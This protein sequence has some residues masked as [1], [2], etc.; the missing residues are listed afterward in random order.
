VISNS[1]GAPPA[2]APVRRAQQGGR[3]FARS[4]QFEWL[5][6]AGLA[7]RGA[8]YA[9]IGVLAIKLAFGNGG[10]TTDQQ[11]A[12]AEIAKQPFGKILMGLMAIGLFGYATWR[13][14]RAII[15]HGKE[16]GKDDAKERVGGIASGISYGIFFVTSLTILFGS[17]KSGNSG[18]DKATGG[19]LGWPGGPILVAIAGIVLIGIGLE[20]AY[21][22]IKKKFLEDSKTE[23][24]SEKVK[25][26]FTGLGVFG[27]LARG[28]VFGLIGYF[29]VKAA[30]DFKAKEAV[31][32]DG[33]L[34]SLRDASY[35]PVILGIVALGLIGFAAYSLADARYRRV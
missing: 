1:A 29:L 8:I 11:G 13:I 15:G 21:K 26:A 31:G 24:M 14:V 4:D 19:V 20:Q 16:A 25:Q 6:R 33:A 5:A 35:G 32:I 27:H 10:K 9:V 3:D 7:A 12:L 28:V 22:G 17:G 23:Q 30:I 18:P 2:P 34:A